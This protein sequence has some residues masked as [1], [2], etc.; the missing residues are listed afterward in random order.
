MSKGH[1]YKFQDYACR[2]HGTNCLVDKT[3][4]NPRIKALNLGC[5]FDKK[6]SNY[7]IEWINLDGAKEVLPDVVCDVGH[8]K[9]PFKNDVF[10]FVY[11]HHSM[12]HFDNIIEVIEELHRVS[13]NNA[14]WMITVPFGY[15]WQDNLWHKTIG[16]HWNSWDKYTIQ[17]RPYYTNVKLKVLRVYGTADGLLKLL[18]F[19]RLWSSL[20]N[21]IYRQITYKLKVIK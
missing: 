7:D 5:G 2:I 12:E 4:I 18:P 10:D 6:I 14:V 17:K 15:S 3:R 19:K 20:F 11:S 8:E 9:L 13:K 1:G 16:W 21:N